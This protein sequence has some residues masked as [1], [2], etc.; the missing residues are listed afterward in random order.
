MRRI[1]AVIFDWAGT[2]VDYGC[3]SPLAPFIEVFR[4]RGVTIDPVTARGP[5]G[6]HK[7]THIER[8]AAL[9]EVVAQWQSVHGRAPS[10]ADVDAMFADFVPL[11]IAVL[12]NFAEPIPGC[13]EVVKD[14][15]A[16]GVRIGSTTGYTRAMMYVLA[17]E[18]ARRG[19]APDVIVAADEVSRARPWP[20]MC[21]RNVMELGVSSVGACVKVD[22]TVA[23][24]DEGLRAGMWTVGVVM[25]GNEIGCTEAEVAAMDPVERER[26]RAE[27]YKHLAEAG[28]H[29][30]IDG[31]TDLP[32]AIAKIE[33]WEEPRRAA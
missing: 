30:V 1:E 8:L 24:I 26:R 5:M 14:L 15:R 7:R 4:Q 23:G 20:D 29:V 32:G 19:F 28:A 31:I 22:D 16:R 18:A 12:K 25:T 21:L 6:T 33:S 10:R 13:V 17:P 27:G 11:Q 3:M 9:P 2:T